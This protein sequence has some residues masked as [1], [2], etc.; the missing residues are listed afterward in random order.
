MHVWEVRSQLLT[1]RW[2]WNIYWWRK[3]KEMDGGTSEKRRNSNGNY[4]G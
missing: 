4:A 2:R 3:E 1:R